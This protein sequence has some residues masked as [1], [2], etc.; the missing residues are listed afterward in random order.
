[1]DNKVLVILKIPELDESYDFMIPVSRKIG[2]VIELL[3]EFV[4]EE[5]NGSYELDVHKNLYN[6]ETGERYNNNAIVIDTNIRN[7]TNLVLI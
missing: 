1:M 3:A 5:T 2:N 6:H 4:K 7:G